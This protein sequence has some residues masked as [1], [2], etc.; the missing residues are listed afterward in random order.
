MDESVY[1]GRE[2][3]AGRVVAHERE[4]GHAAVVVTGGAMRIEDA[5][6]VLAGV[7]SAVRAVSGDANRAIAAAARAPTI[8]NDLVGQIPRIA[9]P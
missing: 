5:R 1:E 6:D 3:V 8:M 2:P 9:R 4:R 7:S